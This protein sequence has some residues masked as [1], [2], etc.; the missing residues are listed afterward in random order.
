[1]ANRLRNVKMKSVD[2]VKRG[3]N[4][5]ADIALYKSADFEGEEDF[6][7]KSVD[8]L[9]FYN[10]TLSESFYGIMKSDVSD[11]EK[12]EL[13][14]KSLREYSDT[15]SEDIIKAFKEDEFEIPLKKPSKKVIKE[16]DEGEKK[17][18]NFEK[19]DEEG[20]EMHPEI[21][22]ALEDLESLKKGMEMKELETIAKQYEIL[23]HDAKELTDTLYNL[24]KSGDSN[25]N[26]YIKVLDQQRELVEKGGFFGEIGKSATYSGGYSDVTKGGAIGKIESI[27]K[28]YMKNDATMSYE[29]ALGKA[30]E[31]NPEIAYEYDRERRAF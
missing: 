19:E 11:E 2:L 26:A 21:K 20:E 18:F 7:T 13:L 1:M 30:W 4:Q 25:Y 27:A 14:A 23:G 15:V 9:D 10:E 6:I 16:E 22:K 12:A 24:K 3:A 8:L 5:E 17:P 29:E 28:G 31:E